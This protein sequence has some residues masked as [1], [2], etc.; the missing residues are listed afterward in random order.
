MVSANSSAGVGSSGAGRSQS[1][2]PDNSPL[3][4]V[5]ETAD[6]GL[7]WNT[8]VVSYPAESPDIEMRPLNDRAINGFVSSNPALEFVQ[9]LGSNALKLGRGALGFV[10][11]TAYE[12]LAM[13]GDTTRVIAATG[14]GLLTGKF[15]DVQ[16][17]SSFGRSNIST[18]EALTS[19]VA[20]LATVPFNV[21]YNGM[22]TLMNGDTEGFGRELGEGAL[23]FGGAKYGQKAIGGY[24]IAIDDIGGPQYGPLASQ[25]GAIKLKLVT[26][27]GDS[28]G[29]LAKVNN[30]RSPYSEIN[31][32]IGEL[33]GYNQAT[34]DLGHISIQA[35][36]KT[37]VPGPDY[38]TLDLVN[39]GT[40]NVWDSKYRGPQ[41]TS[42]PKSIPEAKLNN[43]MP[44]VADSINKKPSGPA[45]SMA[46]DAY[47][48]GRVVGKIFKWP[49]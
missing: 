10:G 2:L 22:T 42:Y 14:K 28:S 11:D 29:I 15:D 8:G 49:Q 38:V 24:G 34:N 9:D 19:M 25:Q 32:A 46:L 20:G 7:A 35:P 44:Q 23:L 1:G 27:D 47:L 17:Y 48:N 37:S 30:G 21:G 33:Q 13:A 36:G 39:D 26:P 31:G 18:G 41:A 40:I 45:K 6:G 5:G 16:M 43:W 3:R 4:V 12:T